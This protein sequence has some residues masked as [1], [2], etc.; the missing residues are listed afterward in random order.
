MGH[1][2]ALA[3]RRAAIKKEATTPIA[4]VGEAAPA[5]A[6]ASSSPSRVRFVVL[7]DLSRFLR[8]YRVLLW[9][10][11]AYMKPSRRCEETKKRDTAVH[12]RP[13][14]VSSLSF[15]LSLSLSLL[16][17]LFPALPSFHS[18]FHP[19]ASSPPLFSTCLSTC[20]PLPPRRREVVILLTPVPSLPPSIFSYP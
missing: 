17:R 1:W 16:S 7:F 20:L 18:I 12:R 2:I 5:A 14:A 6:S 4:S 19:L 11:A 13:P 8:A 15:T 10:F 9:H 3:V